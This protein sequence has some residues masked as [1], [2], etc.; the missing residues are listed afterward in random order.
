MKFIINR[1]CYDKDN[2]ILYYTEGDKS[3]SYGDEDPDNIVFMRDID[4]DILTGITI[5]NF[6]KMYRKKDA[7][8]DILSQYFNVG[9]VINEL[10]INQ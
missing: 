10:N 5:M 9:T 4:T 6:L 3:N 7:R 2:D 1:F 8:I